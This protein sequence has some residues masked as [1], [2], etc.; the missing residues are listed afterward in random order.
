M[1]YRDPSGQIVETLWDV[2][3]VVIGV[4]S[5][6]KNV[7]VG[8]YAGAA[9]DAAGVVADAA[10]VI[11]PG[12]PGGAGTAIKAVRAA[13]KAADAV[14]AAKAAD[15]AADAAKAAKNAE[16]AAEAAKAAEK[17]ADAPK[18]L[19]GSKG[20]PT[21]GKP[22]P[23]AKRKARRDA[24]P[25]CQYCGQK[26]TKQSGKPNSYEGDHGYPKSKGENATDKNLKDSCRTCNREKSDKVPD[27]PIEDLDL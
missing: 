18:A 22:F 1:Y 26:T 23:A 8:N 4:A 2:A 13:D 16:K 7:A 19:A 5:A 12:V 11:V 6:A 14:K 24:E 17:A 21:A 25:P 20:A 15:R 27:G 9:V 10:A 3:N